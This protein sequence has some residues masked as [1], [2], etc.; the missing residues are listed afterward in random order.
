MIITGQLAAKYD[1]TIIPFLYES[2][3]DTY[4]VLD[5]DVGSLINKE[6]ETR[7]NQKIVAYQVAEQK[8]YN[9]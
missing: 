5:S 4:K 7:G 8:P 1:P 9:K 2:L 6:V 3:E